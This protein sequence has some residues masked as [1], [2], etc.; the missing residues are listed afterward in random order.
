MWSFQWWT[1]SRRP[2]CGA[3]GHFGTPKQLRQAPGP[4]PLNT[5]M[6]YRYR[7]HVLLNTGTVQYPYFDKEGPTMET[8]PLNK[9]CQRDPASGHVDDHVRKCGLF[10]PIYLPH[11]QEKLEKRH[12]QSLF[13]TATFSEHQ[14][15]TNIYIIRP[16]AVAA[17]SDFRPTSAVR[18]V[19]VS[20][21]TGCR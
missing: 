9:P 12:I 7:H 10:P 20:R 11:E 4:Q 5:M 19:T 14:G 18:A 3:R 8:T 1:P 13:T 2:S 17:P 21:H 16:S 15:K 6:S